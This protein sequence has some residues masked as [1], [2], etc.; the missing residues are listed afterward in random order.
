[1]NVRPGVAE[2]ACVIEN[3]P[4]SIVAVGMYMV[5]LPISAAAFAVVGTKIGTDPTAQFPSVTTV[6]ATLRVSVTVPMALE[7]PAA[8]C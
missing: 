1:M 3:D 4:L 6:V 5:P 8:S 7:R 2:L